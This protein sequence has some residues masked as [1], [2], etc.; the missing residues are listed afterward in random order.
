[1]STYDEIDPIIK[2][3]SSDHGLHLYTLDRD[4]EIRSVTVGGVK[5]GSRSF[6][7]WITEPDVSGQIE[8]HVANKNPPRNGKTFQATKE[9]LL[10]VLEEAWRIA[11][12]V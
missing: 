6:Q 4:W 5:N 11:C 9:N 8:V 7:I 1:V 12:P 2:K 3:W 10:A